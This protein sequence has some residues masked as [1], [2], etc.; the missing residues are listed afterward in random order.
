[1]LQDSLVDMFKAVDSGDWSALRRFYT[2]QC[3]YERPGFDVIAGV[4]ALIHFYESV[5][6]IRSGIHILDHLVEEK[7]R[8]MASGHFEGMLRSGSA[9]QLQF[10]DVY[11]F[12]HKKIRFRKT[13]F[14]TP[15]A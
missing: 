12:D 8:V 1:M 2:D 3:I 13:F 9:I 7:D 14:F 10:T 6:P 11:V 5:R 4:E 15:L